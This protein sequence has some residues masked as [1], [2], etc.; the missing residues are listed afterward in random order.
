LW[1][2]TN[3]VTGEQ[4]FMFCTAHQ[5]F[6]GVTRS[7]RMRWEV[8]VACTRERRGAYRGLMGEPEGRRSLE[9]PRRR[10]E[11]NIKMELQKLGPGCMDW[12]D[13]AQDRERLRDFMNAILNLL[14]P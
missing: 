6:F 1:S 8:P 11:G 13:L 10:W 5:I 7:I 4:I 9:N 12:I 2:K 14:V 3:D